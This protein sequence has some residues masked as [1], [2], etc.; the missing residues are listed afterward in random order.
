[1]EP[2]T[3][4]NVSV[5]AIDEYG[6]RKSSIPIKIV[7]EA[8]TYLYK[9]GD[10][11]TELTGGWKRGNY[12]IGTFTKEND[13]LNL[14]GSFPADSAQHWNSCQTT[15]SIDVTGFKKMGYKI[16]IDNMISIQGTNKLYSWFAIAICNPQFVKYGSDNAKAY[17]SFSNLEN[18]ISKQ[19]ITG[20]IDITNVNESVY[21]TAYFG[22]WIDDIYEGNVDIYEVWLEK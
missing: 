12:N 7:T 2:E 15:N 13:H 9:E 8:R 20:K 5:S 16:K 11:C 1:M 3:Q 17:Y 18:D 14:Q 19:I 10:E 22:I 6:N 4:Y 21:P